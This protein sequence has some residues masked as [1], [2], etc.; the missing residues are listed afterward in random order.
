MVRRVRKVTNLDQAD[1]EATAALIMR[2]L[3][4][5]PENRPSAEELL[6]DPW[7]SGVE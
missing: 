2:C 4:L 6:K 7:F 1:V 3:R 5:Q